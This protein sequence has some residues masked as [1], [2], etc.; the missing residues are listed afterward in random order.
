MIGFENPELLALLVLALPGLYFTW[1][2]SGRY[3]T[4]V[5]FSHSI[6]IVLLVITAAAPYIN[7]DEESLEQQ[8]IVLLKDESTS[9]SL[10]EEYELDLGDI[11]VREKVIASGNESNL[12]R[13]FERSL[14]P[15]TMHLAVSDF[16]SQE[17]LDGLEEEFNDRNA[18]LNALKPSMENEA[19]VSIE[20]PDSTVPGASNTF[21]VNVHS[22]ADKPVPRVYLDGSR[23]SLDQ[24]EDGTWEFTRSFSDKGSYE[25]EAE[26]YSPDRFEQNNRYYHAVEVIEKPKVLVYGREGTMEEQLEEFY[27]VE[28]S[29]TLPEDLSEYYTVIMKEQPPQDPV[30][31]V[32]RGNGVV[33]TGEY[34][35]GMSVLPVRALPEGDQDQGAKVMI[36]FDISIAAG[37]CVRE[38]EIEGFTICV[39][40][41][42]EGGAVQESKQIAYNLVEH[43][44]YNNRVGA[45]AFNDEAVLIS[46]PEP[47]Y[48]NRDH[49]TDRISRIDTGGPSYYHT[50]LLGGERAL[51]G[52]GNMIFITDGKRHPAG[53]A[54]NTMSRAEAI[55]EDLDVQLITVGVGDEPNEEFLSD[56]AEKGNGFYL[57]ATDSPRLQFRFDA[58]GAAGETVPLAVVNP[59]H[60]ITDGLE[61]SSSAT[62]F[63]SVEPKR[64]A[65]VLVTGTDG[66]EF[67][68]TWR[69]GLGRTAAFTGGTTELSEISEF[70]PRMLTRTVSWTVGDPK[71]KQEEWLEV[72]SARNPETVE[73]RASHNMDGLTR[74]GEDLYTTELEPEE[75]GFHEFNG[76]TYAYNYNS[77]IEK[78]GYSDEMEETVRMTG[79]QVYE[80]GE[81][82]RIKEDLEQFGEKRITTKKNLSKYI[83]ALAF[84]L[85]LAEVGY[86]K[87]NGKK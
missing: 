37:E 45:V 72:D 84:I 60:F 20:G 35:E 43:L 75:T 58:G 24:V 29:E 19:S 80:P 66:R 38:Q 56:L 78:V 6:L 48:L 26:I 12:R 61:L 71:R 64:G 25:I 50:G 23:V 32:S 52:E 3:R 54:V 53:E 2:N 81:E 9:A 47:L 1:K 28:T 15:D 27:D 65:D 18:T 22:T 31:Y 85:F 40:S 21:R 68:T 79:G 33:Y 8:E 39:E 7:V 36:V 34:D 4:V 55:A 62:H 41:E 83:L 86:R 42:G 57:D 69:Y 17:S 13:G 70:D 14:E 11:Q 49:L 59:N 82:T 63:D 30:E 67:L 10:M 16:Q 44:P 87:M 51:R 77:E 74:Q 76:R 46:E 73:V 5:S